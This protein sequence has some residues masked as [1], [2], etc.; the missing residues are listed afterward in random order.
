MSTT[1]SFNKVNVFFT[2]DTSLNIG[3]LIP[4]GVPINISR[5]GFFGKEGNVNIIPYAEAISTGDVSIEG[6]LLPDISNDM[7]GSASLTVGDM[8]GAHFL[9]STIFNFHARGL[10][11]R[12]IG[13]NVLQKPV[14][15]SQLPELLY[16]CNNGYIKSLPSKTWGAR[17][18]GNAFQIYFERITGS[19]IVAPVG[20]VLQFV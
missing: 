13:L 6:V 15:G 10:L 1:Y 16:S 14:G 18:T 12:D 19:T 5:A 11:I 17:Q 4:I 3:G 7:T 9:L 20:G 8:S 2:I